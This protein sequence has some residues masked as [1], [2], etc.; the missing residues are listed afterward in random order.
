MKV[1]LQFF[2]FLLLMVAT[3]SLSAQVPGQVMSADPENDTFIPGDFPKPIDGVVE[4]T[5]MGEKKILQYDHVRESDVMWQKYV[6]RVIDIREKINLPFAYPDRTFLDILM[7]AGKAGKIPLYDPI[8]DTFKRQL[9]EAEITEIGGKSD[10]VM[11]MNLETY[12]EE[13]QVVF[14]ALNPADVK[15]FRIKEVW[16]FDRE[17]STMKVRILGIAPIYQEPKEIE[18]GTQSPERLLFWVY[19]PGARQV[20]AQE[21][22]FAYGNAAANRSWEDVMESRYFSSY[23]FKASNV[24]DRRISNYLTGRDALLEAER[25]KMEIFNYEHDLWTY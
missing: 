24:Y 19:Y 16:Y 2:A 13:P 3:A 8:D 23:I 21:Q 5:M 1:A 17:S 22:A 12:I 4:P 6:W 7:E 11:I 15:R 14:N 10:T 25:I 20:L 9:T 18:D